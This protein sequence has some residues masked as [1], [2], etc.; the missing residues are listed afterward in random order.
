MSYVPKLMSVSVI[1]CKL[2]GCVQVSPDN[3]TCLEYESLASHYQLC[4]SFTPRPY[5]WSHQHQSS[6]PIMYTMHTVFRY[7]WL[8]KCAEVLYR[9]LLFTQILSNY[10]HG[11]FSL[12]ACVSN[13]VV[14]LE[15]S[16]DYAVLYDE[17]LA[18]QVDVVAI[19]KLGTSLGQLHKLSHAA[20]NS[21]VVRDLMRKF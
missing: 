11:Y 9:I 18:S 4:P 15:D 17:L 19:R 1:D 21:I 16:K 5:C 12:L 13:I 8:K 20:S 7:A 14:L 10:G 6:M 3:V 2:Q